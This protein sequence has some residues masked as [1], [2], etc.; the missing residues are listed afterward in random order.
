MRALGGLCCSFDQPVIRRNRAPASNSTMRP[1]TPSG[2]DRLA[3][4][5]AD[6]FGLKAALFHAAMA[7]LP[8]QSWRE[9][10]RVCAA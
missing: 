5:G 9:V 1:A 7:R 3:V 2:A 4:P 10:D 6:D 8:R